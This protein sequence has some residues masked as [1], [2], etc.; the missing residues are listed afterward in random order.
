MSELK[1][2]RIIPFSSK[3]EDWNRW[4]KTFLATATAKGYKEVLKLRDPAADFNNKVYNHLILV[5]QEDITSGIVDESISSK[6]SDRD[7]RLAW[8]NLQARFEPN[9]GA[10]KV[11]L[12]KEFHQLKLGSADKDPDI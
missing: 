7:A 5:C 12:K 3:A 10:A 2:I 4:L 6:F 8:K 9:M 11:Q 1:I